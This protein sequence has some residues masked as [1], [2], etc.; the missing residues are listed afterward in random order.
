VPRG[1]RRRNCCLIVAG[2]CFIFGV[3]RK[4]NKATMATPPTGR[5]TQK[6]QRQETAPV[7]P[8]PMRGPTTDAK[9]KTMPK[10]AEAR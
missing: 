2:G 8:P 6:H 3:W 1:S 7:K 4:K 5:F 9:P 10:M